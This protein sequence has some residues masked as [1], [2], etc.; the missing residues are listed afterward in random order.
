MRPLSLSLS[1]TRCFDDAF[2][3]AGKSSTLYVGNLSFYTSEEQVAALLGRC[4]RVKKVIMGLHAQKR[5]P[6]GFC[7]VE[8]FRRD[9]AVDAERFLDGATLDG[10]ILKLEMDPGFQEGRQYGRGQTG[11]QVRDEFRQARFVLCRQPPLT[12]QAR[13]GQRR[14]KRRRCMQH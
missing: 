14:H 1:R 4:G 13:H 7:F 11:G 3:Q 8:Y 9:S 5:T 12:P 2:R 10:R 6:C